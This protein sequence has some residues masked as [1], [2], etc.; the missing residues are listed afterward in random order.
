MV[1]LVAGYASQECP[2]GGGALKHKGSLETG[3]IYFH[4]NP[5]Y[6]LK[7]IKINAELRFVP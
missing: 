2:G 7:A 6:F 5:R 3:K 4:R 1:C